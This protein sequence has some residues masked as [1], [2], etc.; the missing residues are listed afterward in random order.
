MLEENGKILFTL[1]WCSVD[2]SPS[3]SEAHTIRATPFNY[4]MHT[5]HWLRGYNCTQGW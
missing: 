3:W 1:F 4:I 2:F 5:G